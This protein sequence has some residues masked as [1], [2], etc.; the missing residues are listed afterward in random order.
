MSKNISLILLCFG[1]FE[2]QAQTDYYATYISSDKSKPC[3]YTEAK[4]LH[5]CPDKFFDAP[6]L[7][8]IDKA[9]KVIFK[10][11]RNH[12]ISYYVDQKTVV[13]NDMVSYSFTNDKGEKGMLTIDYK[14][15]MMYD[16][17][18]IWEPILMNVM[19]IKHIWKK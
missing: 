19:I 13:T 11:S 4:G 1:L 12:T 5:K 17:T 10:K 16:A 3:L 2:A 8:E 6:T 14:E 9:E 7:Y 15:K 18:T